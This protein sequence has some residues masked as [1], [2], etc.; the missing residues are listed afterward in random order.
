MT[1]ISNQTSDMDRILLDQDMPNPRNSLG[2]HFA[3]VSLGSHGPHGSITCFIDK[4]NATP[5]T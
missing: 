1:C 5:S 2:P 3:E 4:V